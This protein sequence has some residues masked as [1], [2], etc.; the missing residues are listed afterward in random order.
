MNTETVIR[1]AL[2]QVCPSGLPHTGNAPEED[3]GHSSCYT[4]HQL[5][6]KVRELDTEN[7]KLAAVLLGPYVNVNESRIQEVDELLNGRIGRLQDEQTER[8][9]SQH[10]A[11]ARTVPST[12]T[13]P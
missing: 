2:E 9:R 1:L 3:H 10:P 4:I 7:T 11:N 6:S 8:S 12:L 13:F 5:I